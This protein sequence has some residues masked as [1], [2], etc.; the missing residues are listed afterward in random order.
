MEALA[1]FGVAANVL[2][3]VDFSV[4]LLS[5]GHQIFLA[6]ST[7]KNSEL[8][9]VAKDL[10]ALSENIKRTVRP[11]PSIMGC[12]SKDDQVNT[13]FQDQSLE[14]QYNVYDLLSWPWLT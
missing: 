4:R 14:T 9:V 13:P 1:A 10:K 3:I 12:L 11:A 7:V 8:E 2:Q 6:G 5:T